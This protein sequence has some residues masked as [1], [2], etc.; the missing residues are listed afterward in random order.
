MDKRQA[1]AYFTRMHER[2]SDRSPEYQRARERLATRRDLE[3]TMAEAR[4]DGRTVAE[5]DEE[6]VAAKRCRAAYEKLGKWRLAFMARM[7]GT[8]PRE[9]KRFVPYKDLFEN[10]IFRRAEIN[11]LAKVLIDKQVVTPVEW[12]NY[13]TEE[14]KLFDE[15]L[16]KVFP[17]YKAT[18]FGLDVDLDVAGPMIAKWPA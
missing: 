10:L 5:T 16:E 2:F 15:D 7:L 11:A 1:T 12:L 6:R 3:Q 14:A 13:M 9:D 17:G 18:E 8:V 4:D